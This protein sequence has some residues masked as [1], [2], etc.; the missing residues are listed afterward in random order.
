MPSAEPISPRLKQVIASAW[1]ASP[2]TPLYLEL[3][4]VAGVEGA[5]RQLLS[6][7]GDRAAGQE[8]LIAT[9]GL[10]ARFGSADST[11]AA[12]ERIDPKQPAAVAHAAIAAANRFENAQ[13]TEHLLSIY[14]QLPAAVRSDVRDALLSRPGS[15]LALLRQVESGKVD[16]QEF[17]LDQLRRAALHG[18][19]EI[20]ALVRKLW[21]AI[22]PATPEARLADV[23]RFSNDLRAAAG[24]KRAG[25]A[26]YMKH[27]GVC[28]RLFDEGNHVGPELT[29]ANRGD[30]QALLTNIVDPSSV[31]RK[32]YASYVLTTESGQVLTGVLAEQNAASVTLLDAKNQRTRVRRD[33]IDQLEE[34]PV[35][36]MPE[37]L[38][39]Q[40]TPQQLRDLF[41]YLQQ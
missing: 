31:I 3:A 1:Q 28:H 11:P 21:G 18:D 38:L 26:I 33:E 35:S 4:L 40:L 22:Q 10:L 39:E 12:L 9:L 30:R 13:V 2:S 16:P 15:A 5:Q 25:K 6:I 8:E 34:S 19:E 17:P 37:K 29:K 23:R 24:D 14:P 20:D 36:L 27:C 41:A 7:I 32:E